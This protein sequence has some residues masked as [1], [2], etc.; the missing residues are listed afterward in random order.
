[1]RR[2]DQ[3]DFAATTTNPMRREP[4]HAEPPFDFWDYFDAIPEEDFGGHDCSEGAVDFAYT[5]SDGRFS[6]VIVSSTTK[7]VF[8]VIVLDLHASTV[9]GHRL[10]DFGAEYSL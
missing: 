8:M 1:M 6:H 3:T 4:L 7:N 10:L 5:T 9:H 2:L